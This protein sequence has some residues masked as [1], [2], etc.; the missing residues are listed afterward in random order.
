MT[1]KRIWDKMLDM[2]LEPGKS[3][4]TR[5]GRK[6]TIMSA[7]N[8][9]HKGEIDSFYVGILDK[10]AFL[11]DEAGNFCQIRNTL[12]ETIETNHK[13]DIIGDSP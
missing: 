7:F 3:Y 5:E 12:P 8:H 2:K 1:E 4:L 11:Y 10:S 13:Y 9:K 6:V